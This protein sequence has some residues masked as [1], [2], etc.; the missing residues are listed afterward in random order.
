MICAVSAA[1]CD[2]KPVKTEKADAA[3]AAVAPTPTPTAPPAPKPPVISIEPGVFVV[4]AERVQPTDPDPVGQIASLLTGKPMVE[5]AIVEMDVK[6][7]TKPSQVVTMIAALKKAKAKGAIAKTENRDK[8]VQ[9]FSITFAAPPRPDCSVV[10][11]IAKDSK[12]N[13]WPIGGGAAK[14][15]SKGFAGPDMTLGTE[16][17]R[18]STA[19]CESSILFVGADDAMNWGLVYDLATISKML[20]AGMSKVTEFAVVPGTVVPGRKVTLE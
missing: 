13:V 1:G 9:P 4:G 11:F 18:E 20:G 15:Y 19:R 2:D 10:A 12:I 3:T 7:A 8:V 14:T 6:R 17:V 5:G 16:G